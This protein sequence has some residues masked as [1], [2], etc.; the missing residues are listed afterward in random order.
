MFILM[1]T[2][3]VAP[4][5]AVWYLLVAV[6]WIGF[7]VLEGFD[8][9]VGM[10]YQVLSRKEPEERRVMV[11]TVGPMWG[12]NQ[13]W[14]LTAGG[15]TFAAFP[16][17]YAT[18]FS[19]LYLPLF[20]VLLAL[21][22]R[23]ISFEYRAMN[24]ATPWKNTFDWLNSAG[25]LVVMLVFGVG[26]ANFVRGL[27]VYADVT[28]GNNGMLIAGT[29]VQRFLGL[30]TPF[31]LIGG[32]MFVAAALAHGSMWLG[33][34]TSG[35]VLDKASAFAPK[36]AYA[37]AGLMAVFF[38]WSNLG[39]AQ[40]NTFLNG[41]GVALR[42]VFAVL[43]IVA[44]AAGGWFVAQKRYGIS[45]ICTAASIATMIA[46]I[47]TS[48]YGTLGFVGGRGPNQGPAALNI[49]T[50]S[51]SHLTLLLMTIFACILVPIVLLYTLWAF[52]R[53]LPRLAVSNLPSELAGEKVGAAA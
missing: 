24:Q 17:W 1:E 52:T 25:S 51:S 28:N 30:F 22:V 38:I 33:L 47:C 12:A 4:L 48:V 9:G 2:P 31:A 18:L 49:A 10:L 50:A 35:T 53:F 11:N 36:A 16:G 14:L 29:F 45:F 19:G 44:M 34:K 3:A 37:A 8:F 39:Q 20:L 15:A 40:G 7:F 26:F 43:A 5:Q 6:L 41:F 21:I 32:L 13:V 27:P 23:G 42:W 46:S